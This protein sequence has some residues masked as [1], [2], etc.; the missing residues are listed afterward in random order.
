VLFGK[1]PLVG[2]PTDL[3]E[4]DAETLRLGFFRGEVLPNKMSARV[5]LLLGTNILKEKG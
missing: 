4:G 1:L 5:F 3:Q 2:L